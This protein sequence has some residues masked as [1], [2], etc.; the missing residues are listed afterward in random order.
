MSLS[1]ELI[2]GCVH[3]FMATFDLEQTVSLHQG[4]VA[5]CSGAT[6]GTMPSCPR[7]FRNFSKNSD[8]F[9]ETDRT[10]EGFFDGNPNSRKVKDD[11]L[12][13]MTSCYS[14]KAP[15]ASAPWLRHEDVDGE[16]PST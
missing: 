13:G 7:F 14:F 12:R 1:S 8:N 10:S 4:K 3:F 5:P 16:N 9:V 15:S 11:G 6:K 2:F